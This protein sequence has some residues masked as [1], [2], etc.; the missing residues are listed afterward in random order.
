MEIH[1]CSTATKSICDVD[2]LQFDENRGPE[3]NRLYQD[4]VRWTLAHYVEQNVST[5]AGSKM[6]TCRS[7]L[8]PGLAPSCSRDTRRTIALSS[9]RVLSGAKTNPPMGHQP[10][11]PQIETIK[12]DDMISSSIL[13]NA[14]GFYSPWLGN[15][16]ANRHTP[17]VCSPAQRGQHVATEGEGVLGTR[18]TNTVKLVF[19][20]SGLLDPNPA[21][22]LFCC[23]PVVSAN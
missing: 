6:V 16:Q 17:R 3:N 1:C 9:R 18:V 13:C 11:I 19:H 14:R 8:D 20:T 5:D 2:F 10:R 15:S 4:H 23:R 21:S 12:A 22:H 7:N